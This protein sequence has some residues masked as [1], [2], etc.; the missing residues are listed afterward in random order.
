VRAPVNLLFLQIPVPVKKKP[1]MS[2][3]TLLIVAAVALS[4]SAAPTTRSHH[5]LDKP[6][7]PRSHP[8]TFNE[9]DQEPSAF[10]ETYSINDSL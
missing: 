1:V 6:A 7:S 10:D 2:N 4:V 3:K 5:A 8:V 9:D